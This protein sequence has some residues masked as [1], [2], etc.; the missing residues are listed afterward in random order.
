MTERN[1]TAV[2]VHIVEDHNDALCH[3]YAAIAKKRIPF[4]NNFLI[5]FDS[6]PDLLL[7]ENLVKSQVYD[8]NVLFDRLSIENWIMPAVFAGHVDTILWIKP[9]WSNQIPNGVYHFKIGLESSSGHVKVSC[10]ELYF[11]SEMLYCDEEDLE[12][13]RNVTLHV[14]T[15]GDTMKNA[16]LADIES[17]AGTTRPNNDDDSG[18]AS[19]V[20]LAEKIIREHND[21]FILDI[22]LDFFSTLNP[23]LSTYKSVDLYQRLKS[24]YQFKLKEGE[25]PNDSQARRKLQMEPLSQLFKALQDIKNPDIIME[26]LPSMMESITN[27]NNREQLRLLIVDLLEKEDLTELDWTLVHDAGCTW[28]SPKQVL[29]HHESTEEEIKSLMREVNCFLSGIASPSLVTIARS[30]LDDYC[31]PHQVGMIQEMMCS[32][33]KTL[34]KTP[35]IFQHY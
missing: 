6:H 24:I 17:S 27:S 14:A 23:F 16:L 32:T 22:D 21:R 8:K 29:P 5:H 18:V 12:E 25:T 3:I 31:P 26:R 33:L 7:P 35:N 34:L 10:P 15:L 1:T 30:S 4:S 13:I 9:P 2:A 20:D 19:T 28:D 11:I